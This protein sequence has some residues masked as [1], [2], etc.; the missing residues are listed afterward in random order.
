M[1]ATMKEK[2]D[3]VAVDIA[4]MEMVRRII[5]DVYYHEDPEIFRKRMI[6]FEEGI[7]DGINSRTH[8]K[9]ASEDVEQRVK[10]AASTMVTKVMSSILH[11]QK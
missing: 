8:F 2:I 4:M 10:D 7:V 5:A 3:D 6:T 11:P 1:D 9:G